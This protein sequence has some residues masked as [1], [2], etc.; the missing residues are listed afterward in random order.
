MQK[1]TLLHNP[2]Q[3]IQRAIQ[4]R[5]TQLLNHKSYGKIA[6]INDLR[7]FMEHHIYAVW[8][9]MSLLKALQRD[10][11]CVNLPWMPKGSAEVRHFINEI[12]LGEESDINWEGKMQSHY[13][14]Y[15][16]AM[17]LVGADTSGITDF[18]QS[19][20]NTSSI[21]EAIK[22]LSDESVQK[23]LHFTFSLIA[24]GKS[25]KIASAFTF[26]REDLIPGMFTGI[27]RNIKMEK[28][29]KGLEAFEYYLDRHIELDGDEHGPLALK[30]IESLCGD[31]R[32]K[33]QEVESTAKEALDLRIALW[34]SIESKL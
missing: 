29:N 21:F 10:L 6:T 25:H 34:D 16:D 26:G 15:L 27:V 7:L 31:S 19:I 1:Q 32:E 23:F 28:G 18:T 4:T 24:E 33:W 3:E 12:V 2:I 20:D 14:M 9:F 22:R 11:T 5:Q 17:E 30:L 13:E 8:D